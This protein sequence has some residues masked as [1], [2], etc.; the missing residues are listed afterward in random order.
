MDI[1]V[2]ESGTV[3]V[4][5]G[6]SARLSALRAVTSGFHSLRVRNFR[7][8][9]IGQIISLV[10]TWM[11]TTAEAWVVLQLTNSP[12]ALSFETTLQFLPIMILALYGGVLA[13]RLPKRKTMVVTQ[14]LLLVQ[15]LIF[16]ILVAT[17]S[18]QLWELYL[19][20]LAQGVVNAVDNPV[21]QAFVSEMV[22]RE[23]LVNAVALN[24]MTFNGAR[25]LGP[26]IAGIVISIIGIAPTLFVN[27]VSYVAVIAALLMM[28][29]SEFFTRVT[30]VPQ[31]SVW[32]RLKEGLSYAWHTPQILA[33]LIILAALGTFGFN[34]T[35]VM[36]LIADFVVHTDVAGFGLLSSA[37]GVGALVAAVGTAY[38]GKP[39]M[40]RLFIMAAAFS[41][42]LA[43]T[44]F[45]SS[46]ALSALFL[47]LVGVTGIGYGVGSNTLLQ[48]STPDELRGRVMS[49][50]VLL[51]L[52]STP[53]GALVIGALSDTLGVAV[54]LFVC[55][56]LC[57]AGV[58]IGLV[59][60]RRHHV[61]DSLAAAQTDAVPSTQNA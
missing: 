38:L 27:A 44:A 1:N 41:I 53:I 23:E 46:F 12:L 2:Q 37:F 33:I 13:D 50:H 48:L 57:G 9:I 32:T 24:S 40:K 36:P 52:G 39:G 45:T 20:A 35:V 34:F 10:G 47:G 61:A 29:E 26:A 7:L 49:L 4:K 56:I 28:R 21:R 5:E 58:V 18:I 8:F 59:Y 43:F 19:L 11:Q 15:A 22:G 14:S 31:G 3:A 17:N 30:G 25:V 60:Y 54:A 51:I 6:K 55:A 42:L 16:G